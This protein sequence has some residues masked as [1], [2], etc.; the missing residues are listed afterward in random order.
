MECHEASL[1]GKDD[2]PLLD[3]YV[4]ILVVSFDLALDSGQSAVAELFGRFFDR[5][6]PVAVVRETEPLGFSSDLWDRCVQ[7]GLAG[8]GVVE[9]AGGGGASMCDL[10]LVAEA[11][12][13]AL[14]PVPVV[15]Y[16]VAARRY[17]VEKVVSGDLI[18]T[19][20]LHPPR[21]DCW[22]VVPAGAIAD[23]VIGVDGP[24]TSSPS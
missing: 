8:M 14:A 2:T 21:G 22:P 3:G 23:V 19:V 9:A 15:E 7:I 18:A 6:S 11:A 4:K 17:A 10:A 12:G 1:I 16:T 13:A 5:E 24:A 20:A